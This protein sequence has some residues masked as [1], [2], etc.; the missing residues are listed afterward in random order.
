MSAPSKPSGAFKKVTVEIPVEQFEF[1]TNLAAKENIT[2]GEALRR[3][4]NT[5]KFFVESRD[6]KKKILVEDGSS[7]REVVRK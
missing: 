2:S 7:L 5:E 1:L 3:A 6:A 4:I